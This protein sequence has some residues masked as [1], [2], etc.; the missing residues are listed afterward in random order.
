MVF[1]KI[2]MRSEQLLQRSPSPSFWK[3]TTTMMVMCFA[4]V[5]TTTFKLGH[6]F[7]PIATRTP[8]HSHFV[9]DSPRYDCHHR[10]APFGTTKLSSTSEESAAAED[11]EVIVEVSELAE[12]QIVEMVEVSFINACLQLSQGYVDVLKLFIVAVKAAYENG[13]PPTTLVDKVAVCPVNTAGRPLMPEEIEL[14][15]TWVQAVYLMLNHIGHVGVP[16]EEEK[17]DGQ[18]KSPTTSSIEIG[19]ID[20]SVRDTYTKILPHIVQLRKDRGEFQADEM[21]KKHQD[22]LPVTTSPMETAIV[23]QTIRVLWYTLVVLDE[24]KLVFG[25]E[26]APAPRPNIPYGDSKNGSARTGSSKGFGK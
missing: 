24:E 14:R 19:M 9:V 3:S 13:T 26:D 22:I 8:S 21:M 4:L 25:D 6:S 1:E 15:T 7:S 20:E 5:L 2:K 11:E 12:N 16:S 23:S 10:L 17:E 18:D